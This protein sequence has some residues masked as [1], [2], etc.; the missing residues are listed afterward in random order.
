MIRTMTRALRSS[1]TEE[2]DWVSMY[3]DS[4][5]DPTGHNCKTRWSLNLEPLEV[6]TAL[7]QLSLSVFR[8]TGF[9]KVKSVKG[10]VKAG[11]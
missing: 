7:V 4:L 3:C 2:K 6:R 1:D 11:I 8:L 5:M 10:D 9:P